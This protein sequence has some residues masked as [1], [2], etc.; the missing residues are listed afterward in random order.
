MEQGGQ[1]AAAPAG[2]FPPKKLARQL[3]FTS[4]AY[5]GNPALAAAAAAVSRALQTRPPQIQPQTTIHVQP[6]QQPQPKPLPQLQPKLQPV[7]PQQNHL[8]HVRP[9]TLVQ[10]HLLSQPIARPM[11]TVVAMKP[12]SPKPRP[13]SMH[14]M[15]DGTPTKKKCCNCR[16]SRCLKLYCE[17][18]ASGVYCDGCNC[19]NCFNN[20]ENEAAR[21]DAVDATL[22]RN[23]DAFRPKIGSSPH[24]T[25]RDNVP[26]AVGELPLV[27]KHNKGCHCKKSGCLKKYCECFQANILC[28]ENCKCMDCKNFD[29]S[30]ER[31]ALFHG[32]QRNTM[33]MQQA[34]NAAI[35][36]AIGHAGLMSP[37]N[38]R[39][40][41]T[42]DLALGQT[43]HRMGPVPVVNQQ[44]NGMPIPHSG[45]LNHLTAAAMIPSKVT[46]RPLLSDIV[47]NEDVKELCKLLVVVSGEAAKAF[48]GRKALEE[49]QSEKEDQTESSLASTKDNKEE[50]SAI[51]KPSADDRSSGTHVDEASGSDTVDGQKADGRPMSP[52]TLALM[53]DEEDAV[54]MESSR[55]PTLVPPHTSNFA[56]VESMP[57]VYAEQEKSVL[58]E[59][60]ECLR[61]LVTCGRMKEERFATSF[62]VETPSQQ[63]IPATNGVIKPPA[64]PSKA[65][66][67]PPILRPTPS[68]STK[69]P[70]VTSPLPGHLDKKTKD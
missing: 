48:A 29:G 38:S 15:K 16:H 12:E 51:Q 1:S 43:I 32:D 11:P 52:S 65:A 35:N 70:V 40:R 50:D 17:C 25:I 58:I 47:Q 24:G 22:E 41:K 3:D 19:T 36:G 26:E 27:G 9:P 62:R 59:F 34:A 55:G 60:R 44:R 30:E 53:C 23:P 68:N 57:E 54:F 14:E 21:R 63:D 61:K 13:R 10:Q 49:K 5:S 7:A 28:S 8:P 56:F 39:K 20:V 66:Q 64:I 2:D 67:V 69:L 4:A 31:R 18:F 37:S 46:Y 45:P 6:Q 42:S 33:Y